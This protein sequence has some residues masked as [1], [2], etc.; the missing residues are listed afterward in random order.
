MAKESRQTRNH[1][2]DMIGDYYLANRQVEQENRSR[3]QESE[4]IENPQRPAFS[5]SGKKRK[6]WTRSEMTLFVV[7]ALGLVAI[8]VKYI[9]LR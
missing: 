7:I 2:R 3:Q 9:V 6:P 1:A 8:V 5:E 4:T